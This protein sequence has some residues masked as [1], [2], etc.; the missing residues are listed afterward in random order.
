MLRIIRELLDQEPFVALQI[1][2]TSGDRFVIENPGLVTFFED[3]LLYY[4]PRSDG[5]AF[6]RLNQIV[7]VQ[8]G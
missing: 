1:V 5:R 7:F 6:V 3:H 4:L 8:A 2:V